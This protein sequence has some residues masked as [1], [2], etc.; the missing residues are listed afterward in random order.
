[1]SFRFILLSLTKVVQW[2]FQTFLLSRLHLRSQA[3]YPERLTFYCVFW[4]P[5]EPQ[6]LRWHKFRFKKQVC[7]QVVCRKGGFLD[8]RYDDIFSVNPWICIFYY[9]YPRSPKFS[10][11]SDSHLASDRP[12]V[13]ERTLYGFALAGRS[14]VLLKRRTSLDFLSKKRAT[15][16]KS[17]KLS[18]LLNELIRCTHHMEGNVHSHFKSSL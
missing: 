9:H 10:V 7:L 2:A 5:P 3:T 1:M 11:L 4:F 14:H 13:T 6:A 8:W 12:T 16:R 17:I 15:L 18:F